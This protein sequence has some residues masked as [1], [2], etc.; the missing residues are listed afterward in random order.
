MA[1]ADDYDDYDDDGPRQP[2][3]SITML[4]MVLI[5]LNAGAA[6]GFVYL[7]AMNYQRRQDWTYQNLM[8]DLAKQGLPLSMEDEGPS[9]SRV[10]QPG[11][12]LT[13][14]QLGEAYKNRGGKPVSE[15][16][17]PAGPTFVPV[18]APDQNGTHDYKDGNW[19]VNSGRKGAYFLILS[20]DRHP[21]TYIKAQNLTS[22]MLKDLFGDEDERLNPHVKTLE[23][24]VARLKSQIPDKVENAAKDLAGQAKDKDDN[25]KRKLAGEWLMA[26]TTDVARV[27]ALA[28]RINELKGG[29]LDSM[30]VEAAQRRLL[31]E[32][33]APLELFKPGDLN[34]RL[35]ERAADLEGLKVQDRQGPKDAPKFVAKD[36]EPLPL[37]QLKERLA[38]RFQA[39][40]PADD[41]K[42][43]ESEDSV[44]KRQTIAF[45]LVALANLKKPDGSDLNLYPKDRLE[46]VLGTPTYALALQA[47]AQTWTQLTDRVAEAIAVDRRGYEV[48]DKGIIVRSK[49]FLDQHPLQIARIKDLAERVRQAQ[50]RLDLA[51][52]QQGKVVKLY[53]DRVN[54]ETE[55]AKKLVEARTETARLV[56]EARELQRQLFQAQLELAEA[57]EINTRLEQEIRAEEQKG[58]KAP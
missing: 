37:S 44:E 55:V 40:L 2:K 18:P 19:V 12:R 39:V 32:L 53:T 46:A 54:H 49:A 9:A 48:L 51:R 26:M 28:Y 15:P 24:E 25:A 1:S 27:E 47:N 34:A 58:A 10:T 31:Y 21:R 30:L 4:T 17:E 8:A 5:L 23:Q 52:E 14:Q 35:L 45:L 57:F 3:V 29:E 41:K 11:Y 38:W 42:S 16:F 22:R 20:D 13:D 33:L 36:I 6:L 43:K 7:L 56:A 50:G